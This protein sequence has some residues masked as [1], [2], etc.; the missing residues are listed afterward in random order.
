[1]PA[2]KGKK[3]GQVMVGKGFLSSI[4][5]G[6]K[7]VGKAVAPLIKK[8]GIVSTGLGALNPAAG[9]VARQ[10]G[11]GRR[12]KVVRKAPLRGGASAVRLGRRKRANIVF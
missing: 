10:A 11:Y 12:K 7:T 9:A 3:V 6:I 4:W 1:M 2:R 5:K 8:S